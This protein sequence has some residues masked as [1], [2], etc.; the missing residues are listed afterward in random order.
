M[1][2]L[3]LE[4]WQT[5]LSQ[6]KIGATLGNF[7]GLHLGH[8]ALLEDFL[9]ECDNQS[10]IPVV[11]TF[12]PHPELFFNP[13]RRHLLCSYKAKYE[14][15]E[16]LGFGYIVEVDFST[17]REMTGQEFAQKKLFCFEGLKLL[18]LGHD[19]TFGCDKAD[20]AKIQHSD[21]KIQ[22]YPAFRESNETISS[23][24]IREKL[25]A[26]E[27]STANKFLSRPF[28][29]RGVIGHGKKL[30]RQIGYPTINVEVSKN[31]YAPAFG[32]Y[33]V[34]CYIDGKKYF[35]AMNVGVNPSV[36]SGNEIKWEAHLLDFDGDLYHK[37]ILVRF[38]EFIRAEK[39]F[40]SVEELKEQIKTDVKKVRHKLA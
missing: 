34:H 4:N 37:E 10:L 18:W 6:R 2:L 24:L 3:S 29:V 32:V 39:R 33:A 28:E 17:V 8:Q 15:L 21:L 22:K 14:L 35:G 5:T 26:G 30:G 11:F 9:K 19:F 40:N 27:L 23:S 38:I 20:P 13:N 36:D 7:D 12:R 31:I 25:T 1:E 16:S